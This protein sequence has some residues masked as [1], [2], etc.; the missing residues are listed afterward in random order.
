MITK[1]CIRLLCCLL[2][3]A[4]AVQR[5]NA[6]LWQAPAGQVELFC[7]A[8]LGYA[9][10]NWL[11]LYDVQI[12][13]TP[14][15]RWHL[16]HDWTVSA[17]G[18]I[19]AVSEGYTYRDVV[20]KYWRVNMATISRQ[21]HFTEAK[22]H[23][24]LTAGWFGMER[25]GIDVRWMWPVTSWLMLQAQTGVTAPWIMGAD[26]KGNYDVDMEGNFTLTG[27]A[28]ANIYLQPWNIE[29]RMTGGRYMAGDY[30]LQFDVM[31][32][33]SHCTLLA[34]AQVTIGEKMAS[35][36]DRNDYRTNGGFKVIM[37]LPPYK[38]SSRKMVVRPAS[39]FRLTNNARA[40]VRSARMYT[41]DPEENERE[42]QIDVNWGLNKVENEKRIV[43]DER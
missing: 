3:V 11:R 15:L 1:S 38:K 6:Q 39:N 37:M 16:G 13:A 19:P 32:H 22:Q 30:G 29:C 42:L 18:L 23:L 12:N 9:D 8:N 31:R 2:L 25:Y 7:G 4:L 20:N 40:N 28:G 10:T 26:F 5:A 36:Y 35:Q 33:F 21:L 14:G 41:T 24:K 17:Q 27:L 34:F 43:K